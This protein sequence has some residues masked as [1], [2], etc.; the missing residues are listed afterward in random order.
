MHDRLFAAAQG[1]AP[2][3]FLAG[4]RFDESSLEA[5]SDPSITSRH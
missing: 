2:L 4:V 3:W 5:C 1:I